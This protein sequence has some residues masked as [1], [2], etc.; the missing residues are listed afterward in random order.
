M[1]LR[2][3]LEKALS[4]NKKMLLA[5]A[6]RFPGQGRRGNTGAQI[7]VSVCVLLLP[8]ILAFAVLASHAHRSQSGDAPHASE[9][10]AES[11]STSVAIT[12]GILHPPILSRQLTGADPPFE[13]RFAAAQQGAPRPTT[14]EVRRQ[15]RKRP[16]DNLDHPARQNRSHICE[17]RGGATPPSPSY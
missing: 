14:I 6:G 13:D 11:T 17:T 4:V 12:E 9:T 15:Q 3:M 8:P 16:S 10:M 5:R 1:S 7:T 2:T